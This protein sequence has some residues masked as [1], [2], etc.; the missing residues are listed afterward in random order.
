M[1]PLGRRKREHQGRPHPL[2]REILEPGGAAA[3]ASNEY[4]QV[5]VIDTT[6]G[7]KPLVYYTRA[8]SWRLSPQLRDGIPPGETH[9]FTWQV[10][11]VREIGQ[12]S[13]G[14]LRVTPNGRAS[15]VRSFRWEGG[16]KK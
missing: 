16:A 8:T 10:Q 7:G 4:Y 11:V 12:D 15:R 5:T 3:D 6:A 9:V 2:T 14:T 1:R 13:D